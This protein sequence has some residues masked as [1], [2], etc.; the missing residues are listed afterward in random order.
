L[1]LAALLASVALI[2]ATASIASAVSPQFVGL[3]WDGQQPTLE[4]PSEWDVIQH[5]GTELFRVQGQWAI[6]TEHGNWRE[7]SAWNLTYDKYFKLA[8]ERGITLLPYLYGRNGTGK[9]QKQFYL[10]SGWGEWLEFVWTFVQRYGRG[11]TFWAA[12]PSLPYRPVTVWEVWNE[13]NRA[14]NNPGETVQPPQ[15]AEFFVATSKTITEAQN[16]VRKAGEPSDTKVLVG[17]LFENYGVTSWTAETYFKKIAENTTLNNEFKGSNSG[18]G[19]HPYPLPNSETQR[20][21]Y[22]K[23]TVTDTRNYLTS[24]DSSAKPIWITE[25]G[26]PIQGDGLGEGEPQSTEAEQAKLLTN[27]FNWLKEQSGAKNLEYAA[28]FNYKDFNPE[29]NWANHCGLRTRLGV[30]RPAWYAYL[31]EREKPVW[32]H[33]PEM[34]HQATSGDLWTVSPESQGT[35][36]SLGLSSGT[37]PDI[38]GLANGSYETA[39]NSGH[40]WTYSPTEGAVQHELLVR[41]ATSP[42]IA[43][44]TNGTLTGVTNGSGAENGSYIVAFQADTGDLWTYSPSAPGLHYGLGLAAG[45]S[46]DI[47][48]LRDGSYEIAFQAN[49]GKLWTYSP[50]SK[51]TEFNLGM[52]AGTSP[53]VAALSNGSYE[54]AFQANTGK[55]WTYSPTE[56]PVEH[57]LGMA[58]GTSPSVAPLLN[59]SYEIAFQANTGKL[60]T[61]SPTEGTAEHNIG[62]REGTSPSVA[63]L[64]NGSYEVA[65][66]ANTGT[67]WTYSPTG[68]SDRGFRLA[69]NTNPSI[70]SYGEAA[71]SPSLPPKATTEAATE[72]KTTSVT[73][74]GT[75]NPVGTATS[76]YFEYGPT[77]SYG[78]KTSAKEAGSGTSNVSV[79]QNLTGLNAGATYHF[80][81]VAT[82]DAGTTN[83]EDRNVT[84]TASQPPDTTI[85]GGST[86]KVTP[87]VSF[88]FSASEGG[89]SFECAIDASS[90]S[91]CTSPRSYEG[92]AEGSHTF[93][94]R[95]MG[96]GGTDPTPAERTVNVVETA[97]AVSGV[98]V[99]DD[100]GRFEVP[101]K[102]GKWTK[103]SW[104]EEI[105]GS[106]TGSWHGYGANGNH[107]AS[108]YWNST[109]FSDANAGLLVSA[110]LGTGPTASGE[111]LSLWIDM[112][113]PGSARSGYEVRFTGTGG[114]T[115]KVELSNWASGHRTVLE[116]KEGV[117][118]A[119]NTTFV[120]TETGGRLTLWTGTTSFSRVLTAYDSTYSSGYAGIEAYKGEG[121][122]YNFRAGNVQ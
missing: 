6:V 69:A 37:S 103:A 95:A 116:A 72:V 25:F 120:L 81:V 11:G 115:Y 46:P 75:V 108:A 80:R 8:A 32:P 7:E 9:S 106:W 18:Y 38:A 97:K 77:A 122:A 94:V 61:Y 83:G 10:K 121:T 76:Y 31:A 65:V 101:L 19:L 86:G 15:Y 114:S 96:S 90:Y 118:L 93:K 66:Q 92:L 73:L 45:T 48:G 98:G 14:E 52:A 104:A 58:A 67:L 42:S 3:N 12:H 60:W 47:A 102:T 2:A 70:S 26:W 109:T 34:A 78:T 36:Y 40:L 74:N 88:T 55:L 24:Y 27:S 44:I 87:D 1:F 54:I 39:F 13:E 5:T 41:E 20:F 23:S 29:S 43:A 63:E 110:T 71:T 89:A 35:H 57:N 111:Y 30:Y 119:K 64:P 68:T 59:G 16:A 107:L 112:P 49:S 53:S 100:F 82:S 84:T 21:E 113:S 105:G 17:G 99:L 79:S 85:T 50:A 51:A 62:M 117:S 91:S 56:G 4:S 22:F 33:S 28:W